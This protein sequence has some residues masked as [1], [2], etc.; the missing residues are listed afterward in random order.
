MGKRMGWAAAAAAAAAVLNLAS[1]APARA[2]DSTVVRLRVGAVFDAHSD[3]LASPLHQHGI[4]VDAGLS[5]VHDGFHATLTGSGNRSRSRFGTESAAFEDVWTASMDVGWWR[6]IATLGARTDVRLGAALGGFA[7]V[8]R[9]QY[10]PGYREYFADMAFP[11]SVSA[12]LGRALG[13]GGGRLDERV[14][15]GLMTLMLRSPFAGT[16]QLP[17]ATWAA[18]WDAQVIRHRLRLTTEASPH[19]HLFVTH[20]LMILATNRERP[21]RVVRQEVSLGIALIRG[22]GG[23]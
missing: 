21:L 2:Q 6:R 19:V 15:V 16:K 3:L 4:G 17:P 9:H 22:G 7:F 14:D 1:A 8:R 11:L 20:G 13:T 12:G 18:P 23:S 10:S 5:L